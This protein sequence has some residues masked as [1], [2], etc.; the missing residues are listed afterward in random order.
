MKAWHGSMCIAP[1]D[2]IV[3]PA[4]IVLDFRIAN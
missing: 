3:S 1:C 2:G 4:Y